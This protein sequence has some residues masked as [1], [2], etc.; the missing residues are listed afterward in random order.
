MSRELTATGCTA[1]AEASCVRHRAVM[2]A[3]QAG[4][5]SQRSFA[6]Q[7]CFDT[8]LDVAFPPQEWPVFGHASPRRYARVHVVPGEAL[9]VDAVDQEFEEYFFE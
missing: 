4:R 9:P 1:A 8:G 2:R 3:L 5:H 7:Q 6:M